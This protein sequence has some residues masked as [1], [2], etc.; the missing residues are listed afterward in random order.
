LGATSFTTATPF[1]GVLPEV[2]A[3]ATGVAAGDSVADARLDAL[4]SE[5]AADPMSPAKDDTYWTGKALGKAVRIVEIADQLDVERW[6]SPDRHGGA[7]GPTP[8]PAATATDLYLTSTG[9]L[10][11]AAGTVATATPAPRTGA[12]AVGD[13]RRASSSRRRT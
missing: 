6:R 3:V 13:P 12:D 7:R 1:T 2:P 10:A 4:L 11:T 8:P 5:G 9:T